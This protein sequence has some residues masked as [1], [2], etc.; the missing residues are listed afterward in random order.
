MSRRSATFCASIA[1]LALQQVLVRRSSWTAAPVRMN[2]PMTSQPRSSNRCA[3]TELSTP[4]L[5]AR[6]TRLPIAPPV[7]W[8]FGAGP[9]RPGI[10]KPHRSRPRTLPAR[11]WAR[12]AGDEG[13]PKSES[14]PTRRKAA[15]NSTAEGEDIADPGGVDLPP[16]DRPPVAGLEG[17]LREPAAGVI[18][19]V[20]RPL[21]GRVGIEAA[22]AAVDRPGQVGGRLP[23]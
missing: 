23:R 7:G 16:E 12:R 8:S 2:R 10:P 9:P 6:T 3:A 19:H 18:A 14:T 20:E 21:A 13:A 22:R 17:A 1:S 5:I 11:D 15:G 4:P